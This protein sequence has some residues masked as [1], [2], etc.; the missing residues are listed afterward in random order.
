MI[1]R[2]LPTLVGFLF[3]FQNTYSQSIFFSEGFNGAFPADWMAVKRQGGN[4]FASNWRRTTTGPQGGYATDPLNSTTASGGW[5]IFDS[6][7]SCNHPNGGQDV[8]LISPPIDASTQ[9]IVWLIFETYYRSFNDRPAIRIG[10]NLNDLDSWENIE[11]FP[12]IFATQFGGAN[13]GD[14]GLN[15]QIIYMNFTEYLAG[16]SNLRFAFQFLSTSET[17]NGGDVIGCAFNWQIDDVKLA[18][19]DPRPD[20]DIRVNAF[21]GVAPNAITPLT[22]IEPIG[23]LADI[24]NSGKTVQPAT[25]LQITIENSAGEVVHQDSVLFGSIA[26]DSTVQNVFFQ[27]EYT[28][29]PVA[30]VYTATYFARTT[31]PDEVPANNSRSFVFEISDTLFAKQRGANEVI[32][33]SGSNSYTFGNVFYVPN[34][35]GLHARY[36]SFGIANAH[37][38]AGK[39]VN[40]YLYRWNGDENNDF[41]ANP[42]EYGGGPVGANSYTFSGSEGN[43]LISVPIDF[44]G[45][46]IALE[47]N[48]HYIAAVQ[49]QTNTQQLLFMRVS[50][51]YDYH[52]SYLYTD[53]MMQPRYAAVIDV[54]NTG[55]LD[56]TGFGLDLVPVVRLSVGQMTATANR[57]LPEGSAKIFPNPV[58]DRATIMLNLP[59]TS[60]QVLLQLYDCK[61]ALHWQRQLRHVKQESVPLQ[62]NRLDP[63]VYWLRVRTDSGMATLTVSVQ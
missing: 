59:Q 36:L 48:A 38:L 21:F 31:L 14:Q 27:S 39:T 24:R 43:N 18:D 50:T 57:I 34:G 42:E 25:T 23:F 62:F 60:N 35:S 30:E 13:E 54:G 5:M 44:E 1:K 55:S 17:D 16:Q 10:S 51:E 53:S 45:G 8:W 26:P 20:T 7:L 3:L 15:P 47:A 61:G 40:T 41:L 9:E 52:A 32:T 56:W 2:Y 58:S 63:G 49:Y 29:P 46:S 12:G 33:A 28:P 11:V 22:Q 19:Y 6:D 37:Q 4:D